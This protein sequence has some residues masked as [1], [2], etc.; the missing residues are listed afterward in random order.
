MRRLIWTL[1]C[2]AALSTAAFAQDD[3]CDA[4]PVSVG[5]AVIT[6]TNGFGPTGVG[7]GMI[8][9]ETLG[10]RSQVPALQAGVL[11]ATMTNRLNVFANASI[12]VSRNVG[13]AITNP[14]NTA[15]TV[16]MTLRNASGTVTAVN[17]ISLGPLQQTSKY[18]SEFFANVVNIL[19]DFAGTLTITSNTPVGVLAV[20]FNGTTFTSIP[21]TSL[22]TTSMLTQ[23]APNVGGNN[24]VLLPQFVANGGWASQIVVINNGS[25]PLTIRVDLFKQDGTPLVATLNH[26]SASSYQNIVIAP[27]G[28]IT[29]A[30]L[31]ANGFSVF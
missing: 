9:F 14:A 24:G 11:P 7:G 6:A 12:Q 2:I 29:L 23:I 16:T 27:G 17:S 13:V 20:L 21:I 26:K 22:S 5:Y 19:P 8:A 1:I 30:P 3:H 31:D 28:T 18:I 25:S 4:C 10:L 15:A